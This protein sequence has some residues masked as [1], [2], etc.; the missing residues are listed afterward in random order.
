MPEYVPGLA[1]VPVAY[2]GICYIDGNEGILEYRG[3]PMEA[4][5]EHS[6]FEETA[7]LLVQGHLPTRSEIEAFDRD[8]R[9]HRRL[10]YK[11]VDLIKCLPESGHPMEALQAAV[12]ALGMFYG[13]KHVKDPRQNYMST[14]R[15]IAKVPTIVAAYYRLRRGDE[16]IVPRDELSHAA[17]F[18]YMLS[19]KEPDPL[20][21]RVL[22][23]A[24]ILHAEHSMN[25]STFSARV[26]GSTLADP[27]TV[28]SSA[29]GALRGP[30][31][32]GANEEVMDLLTSLGNVEGV[33]PKIEAMIREKKKIMGFGHRVYKTKDPRANILQGLAE[34]LAAKFPTA[35]YDIAVQAEKVV[36]EHLAGKGVYPN[37]D[38]YSGIV[39]KVL[40]IEPEL[41]TPIFAISRVAG[42]LAHWLEQLVDNRIYRPDQIYTAEHRLPYVPIDRRG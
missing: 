15:L 22:D 20:V 16:H 41:Y 8:L 26:T 39:Y 23:V 24:L 10:K 31:H 3:I 6:T 7:F 25:A 4:L 28:I 5:A 40:G 32:G 35:L 2:S 27:Y 9:T 34:E 30:L 11:I 33:R 37:V 12:A 38:F 18:L 21:S 14:V 19:G 29:I 42:W 13:G 36:K 1:G 17:N